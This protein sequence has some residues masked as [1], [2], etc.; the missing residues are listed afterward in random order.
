M[1]SAPTNPPGASPLAHHGNQARHPRPV[2]H[3]NRAP[4]HVRSDGPPNPWM[5]SIEEGW[6]D[7]SPHDQGTAKRRRTWPTTSQL[8]VDPDQHLPPKLA[9][10]KDGRQNCNHSHTSAGGN[11]LAKPPPDIRSRVPV[12]PAQQGW[13]KSGRLLLPSA[14]GPDPKLLG[15][16]APGIRS[17]RGHLQLEDHAR[18]RARHILK[19][20]LCSRKC[21]AR[22]R[23]NCSQL[24]LAKQT[25]T[26]CDP[27]QDATLRPS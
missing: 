8:Q 9:R 4:N 10:P 25:G 27:N 13:G 23:P 22:R 6:R 20:E 21:V 17:T 24:H 15:F 3:H 16:L 26:L 12:G 2:P 14:P 7:C 1:C 11:A 19:G 5:A 18:G